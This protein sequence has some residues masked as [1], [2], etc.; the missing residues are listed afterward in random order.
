MPVFEIFRLKQ[1][2]PKGTIGLAGTA[3]GTAYFSN[4]R[5]T[6]TD[7]LTFDPP[8]AEEIPVGMI[9]VWKLS[10]AFQTR[11]IEIDQTSQ[12]QG[13]NDLKW[14]KVHASNLGPVN[15]SDYYRRSGRAADMVF[16]R[17]TIESGTE[18][19]MELK[20]GYSDVIVIFLNGQKLFFG[21]SGYTSRDPS[22]LRIVGL[23]DAV[24][25]PLKKGS[26]ELMVYVAEGFSGWG[27]MC[28]DGNAVF[29]TDVIEKIW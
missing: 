8:P 23:N 21:N 29:P 19:S 26:N 5:Y 28:Q 25:L 24:F 27:F 18:R 1:D 10:Q 4:F 11:E 3:N 15:I 16:A 22:F 2:P 13:L 20:F 14:Q 12:Q 6:V 7:D 17:T 9:M